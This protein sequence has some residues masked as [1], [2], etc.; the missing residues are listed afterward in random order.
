MCQHHKLETIRKQSKYF[1][2]TEAQFIAN[3]FTMQNLLASYNLLTISCYICS[4]ITMIRNCYKFLD[5]YLIQTY[6]KFYFRKFFTFQKKSKKSVLL[7][8]IKMTYIFIFEAYH[9]IWKSQ[10]HII[11]NRCLFIPRR[12][13]NVQLVL[14]FL[15]PD[16]SK[17][18]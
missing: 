15:V 14:I 16:I 6:Y 5:K 18:L 8:A 9:L 2:Q 7:F 11:N 17:V 13:I 4:F 12:Y 10:W 3:G 1:C